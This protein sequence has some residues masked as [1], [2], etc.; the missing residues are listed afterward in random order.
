MRRSRKQRVGKLIV[1][2]TEFAGMGTRK[3]K[4]RLN[5][6]AKENVLARA[7]RTAL[8]IEDANLSAKRY[9]GGDCGGFTYAQVNYARKCLGIEA[10]I[11]IAKSEEWTFG[12][13]PSDVGQTTGII[14]FDIPGVGQVSWHYSPTEPLPVYP[15]AWDG[16][17][18]STLPKL[19]VATAALLAA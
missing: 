4:L 17:A 18:G 10:L 2:R 6:L 16:Q 11:G 1:A 5:K 14:Y 13:Q 12:V 19:G 8:E 9:F 7:I 3:A 15:G